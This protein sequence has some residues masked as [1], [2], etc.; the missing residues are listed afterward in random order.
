PWKAFWWKARRARKAW[1]E[2]HAFPTP[3]STYLSPTAH[4]PST[5]RVASVYTGPTQ[6][7]TETHLHNFE[8]CLRA[9][10]I[11]AFGDVRALVRY[12]EDSDVLPELLGCSSVV[13]RISRL[14]AK[15]HLVVMEMSVRVKATDG[16]CYG[17]N[18][19]CD[20]AGMPVYSSMMCSKMARMIEGPHDIF[21][22]HPR[23][24]VLFEGAALWTPD[25]LQSPR[26]AAGCVE[27]KDPIQ[28]QDE[29]RCWAARRIQ[30]CFRRRLLR[31]GWSARATQPWKLADE[32]AWRQ[33]E[34]FTDA[35]VIIQHHF[36]LWRSWRRKR[37]AAEQ[38]HGQPNVQ[39]IGEAS[40]ADLP[41]EVS[42]TSQ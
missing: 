13:T 38:A 40:T 10:N 29:V 21:G 7:P 4:S 26:S 11:K 25:D 3:L 35:A 8:V 22:K 2:Q 39:W 34:R 42:S 14:T 9:A 36:R 12:L 20:H 28:R 16:L 27:T 18:A 1:E 24:Q 41:W 17:D 6:D 5:K 30:R 37:V 19:N 23:L 33:I 31:D 32:P 15:G